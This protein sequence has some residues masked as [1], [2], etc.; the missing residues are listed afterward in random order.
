V[1]NKQRLLEQRHKGYNKTPFYP[2]SSKGVQ[3]PMYPNFKF[4]KET[5][6]LKHI[7]IYENQLLTC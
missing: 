5:K 1:A 6:N 2:N 4:A 3:L 7:L